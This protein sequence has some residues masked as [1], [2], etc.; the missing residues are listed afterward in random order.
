[1]GIPEKYQPTRRALKG[2]IDEVAIWD[3]SLTEQEIKAHF[4][5]GRPSLLD[6]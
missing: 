5:V 3:R 2:R 1:M 6:E 4:E